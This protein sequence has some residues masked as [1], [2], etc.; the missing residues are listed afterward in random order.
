MRRQ[1][2]WPSSHCKCLE[3]S[4]A[5]SF[6]FFRGTEIR[7]IHTNTMLAPALPLIGVSSCGSAMWNTQC[8]VCLE[9]INC[10]SGPE[11]CGFYDTLGS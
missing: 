6:V 4:V 9:M 5:S 2:S 10:F 8:S 3:V 11:A 1:A 7:N